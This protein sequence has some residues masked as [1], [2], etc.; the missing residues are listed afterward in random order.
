[1]VLSLDVLQS[2]GVESASP[3]ATLQEDRRQT[4]PLPPLVLASC[5]RCRRRKR[6]QPRQPRSGP[7]LPALQAKPTSTSA[8]TQHNCRTQ[9]RCGS[10]LMPSVTAL[11]NCSMPSLLRRVPS[12]L[13]KET[14]HML[15]SMSPVSMAL[16]NWEVDSGSLTRLGGRNA[17][18]NHRRSMSQ[19][20]QSWST[21]A[22]QVSPRSPSALKRATWS[23][24]AVAS[25]QPPADRAQ[26][27]ILSL[28]KPRAWLSKA[29][30]ASHW[31]AVLS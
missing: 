11:T 10:R 25:Q 21:S 14:S 29:P 13:S 7:E 31:M 30:E 16:G 27:M 26:L 8:S 9:S 4:L 28:W 6:P 17:V 2:S 19:L 24:P 12:R 5:R 23:K 1:M 22:T 20:S 3:G 15:P 18:A